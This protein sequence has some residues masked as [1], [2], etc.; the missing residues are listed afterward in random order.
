[1][2]IV[3]ADEINEF[4]IGPVI[5]ASDLLSACIYIWMCLINAC[6][7]EGNFNARFGRLRYIFLVNFLESTPPDAVVDAPVSGLKVSS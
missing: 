4:F 5:L 7:E 6:I 3:V 2:S 1:M